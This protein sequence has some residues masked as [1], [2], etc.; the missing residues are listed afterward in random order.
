M[1]N[2]CTI[3]WYHGWP[4]DALLAIAH[5]FL[6]EEE[7][8]LGETDRGTAIEMLIE[9]Q[10]ST[11]EMADEYYQQTRNPIFIPSVTYIDCI[12]TFTKQMQLKKA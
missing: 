9:F 3:D 11:M 6:A 5:R 7:E 12:N 1:I 2:C 8:S 10:T 4:D